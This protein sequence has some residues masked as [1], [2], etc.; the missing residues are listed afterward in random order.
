ME[1]LPTL[2]LETENGSCSPEMLK[3]YGDYKNKSSLSENPAASL[4][5]QGGSV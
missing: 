2:I 3:I 1:L 5:Q 4:K